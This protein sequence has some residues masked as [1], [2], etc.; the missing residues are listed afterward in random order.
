[1]IVLL[2]LLLACDGEPDKPDRRKLAEARSAEVDLLAALGYV[3]GTVDPEAQKRGVLEHDPSRTSPGLSLYASRTSESAQ[4][5]D[6]DGNVVFEWARDTPAAWQHVH[7]VPETGDLLVLMKDVGL[8]RLDRKGRVQ[9]K[10]EGRFHHDLWMDEDG[11][12]HA[13]ARRATRVPELHE[14]LDVLEDTVMVL[15]PEGEVLEEWSVLEALRSSPHA[16]LLPDLG[17]L[18]VR[19]GSATDIDI[20]HTNHIERIG[21]SDV[22]ADVS[23]GDLLLSS[24]NINAVYVLDAET[25]EVRWIWGPGNVVFQHHPV[26]VDEGRVLLFDNGRKKSR[27]LEVDVDTNAVAWRYKG[28]P[29][30]HSRTRGSVQRLANG[31]TLITVS[32][33]GYVREVTPD[34]QMVW[35]FANPDVDDEGLRGAIWRM[36]RYAP[37]SLPFLDDSAG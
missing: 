14:S 22:S 37:G 3:D 21:A 25:H 1:M 19:K 15:S 12:I 30:F 17:E 27:V 33:S 26:W 36:T 13:L 11:T 34:G 5:I 20:L 9:W 10:V 2:S 4:L 32:D 29:D 35:S 16:Y 24:R 31:N 7:L 6:L 8:W 28:P 23:E 18:R